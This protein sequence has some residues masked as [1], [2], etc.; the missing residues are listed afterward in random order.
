MLLP[1]LKL[2]RAAFRANFQSAEITDDVQL[3]KLMLPHLTFFLDATKRCG[4]VSEELKDLNKLG[5][6][7]LKALQGMAA[8]FA[9]QAWCD[10]NHLNLKIGNSG[11]KVVAEALKSSTTRFLNLY[12]NDIGDEGAEAL[13]ASLKSNGNLSRLHLEG[14]NIGDGGAEALAASL[15]SNGSLQTLWLHSNN[16]GDGGAEALA[17]SLKSNRSLEWL[18][19]HSNNIGDRG[20]E[21][22]HFEEAL[23]Q[24]L[25]SNGSLGELSL[26]SNN[27][28]DRGAE[29]LAAGLLQNRSLQY[30]RLSPF[31]SSLWLCV[32]SRGTPGRQALEEA[33]KIKKE[34]G[35][36]VCI[37]RE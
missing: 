22:S 15:K 24:S 36:D 7:E 32:G 11:A 2:Q 3:F 9:G 37:Y 14:N 6:V 19:L 17:Q 18:D 4:F 12:N 23:A 33:E 31:G 30:L 26:H 8:V 1:P 35:D 34:R 27:I 5:G 13:A 29:A 16:I 25:K 21:A 10:L 28:G 20:A